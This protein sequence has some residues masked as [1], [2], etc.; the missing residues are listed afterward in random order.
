MTDKEYNEPIEA[1]VVRL[2]LTKGLSLNMFTNLGICGAVKAAEILNHYGV[3][4]TNIEFRPPE[5]PKT[6]T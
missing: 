4:R 2:Y 6:K 3:M 5:Y 1:R